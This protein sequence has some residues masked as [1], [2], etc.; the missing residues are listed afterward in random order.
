M[1]WQIITFD[2]CVFRVRR[3]FLHLVTFNIVK[4]IYRVFHQRTHVVEENVNGIQL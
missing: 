3:P 2:T 1:E 4:P